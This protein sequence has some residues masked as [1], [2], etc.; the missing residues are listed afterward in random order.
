MCRQLLQ[1][2]AT[3]QS[4]SL[5]EESVTLRRQLAEY[6]TQAA[7]MQN[8]CAEHVRTIS[9]GNAQLKQMQA[10][11]TC[12]MKLCTSCAAATLY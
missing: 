7:A 8:A 4:D 5:R 3:L 10:K 6:Q 12:C 9:A 11:V 2:T 1:R